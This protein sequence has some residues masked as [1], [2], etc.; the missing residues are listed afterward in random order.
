MRLQSSTLPRC[1]L[2]RHVHPCTRLA[3]ALGRDQDDSDKEIGNDLDRGSG[4]CDLRKGASQLIHIPAPH[5]YDGLV[6]VMGHLLSRC[7]LKTNQT[8]RQHLDVPG[9]G[10]DFNPRGLQLSK[11]ACKNN[12]AQALIPTVFWLAWV[13]P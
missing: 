2:R 10:I 6:S 11:M 4:K 1:A 13:T 8:H 9:L 5:A 3:L 7:K 12:P